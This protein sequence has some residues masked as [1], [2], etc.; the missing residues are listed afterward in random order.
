MK[1]RH[2]TAWIA[3]KQ[4]RKQRK[5]RYNAPLHLKSKFL[6]AHVSK[7]LKAKHGLR[8]LRVRTGDKVRILRGQFKDREGKVERVDAKKSKVFVSKV[9]TLKKDGATRVPYPLD[10]S[11]LLIVEF[12][13]TDKRRAEMLKERAGKTK[14]TK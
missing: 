2:S 5:F 7:D 8:S 10:A 6:T 12:D 11:N 9:D 3:S 13:M 4:P 1:A 14:K